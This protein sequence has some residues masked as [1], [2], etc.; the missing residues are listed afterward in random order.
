MTG[1]RGFV[2][3]HLHLHLV[4][5]GHDV[6]GTDLEDGDLALPGEAERQVEITEP[7]LV[8]HLAARYGRLLCA[9]EPHRAVG[10][11]AAAT[12]EL[13]DACASRGIPVFYT[14]SSEVYGD[15]G[16]EIIY[17]SSELRMPTTIYGL[18]KRWGEEALRMYLP[19]ERLL[20]V[21]MNMLYGPEQV[22]GYGRC[23]L[24]TFIR[25][26]VR[27][28][29]YQVHSGTSR[30]W[31]YIDDAVEALGQ[32]IVERA[33]GIFNLGNP[34]PAI[35]M[36]DVGEMVS[37]AVGG[38]AYDV[39]EPPGGTQI[40]HKNYDCEKLLWHIDWKPT[41]SLKDGIERTVEWAREE[42]VRSRVEAQEGV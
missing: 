42:E 34:D 30:S 29:P 13:A 16:H 41:V 33:S 24:A 3:T 25:Q 20:I 1:A 9:D 4:E 36:T 38:V 27:G 31:L 6:V 17:E 19:P 18:S 37:E 5:L 2:G 12:V 28:L 7:D 8:C 15:H 22:G 26:A 39:V 32:L 10:D 23:S 11:N 21:R 35:P 14:S 40:K